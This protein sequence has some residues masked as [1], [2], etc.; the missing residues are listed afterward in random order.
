[1]LVN[2]P[3]I[4]PR[5]LVKICY[6]ASLPHSPA[7]FGDDH[8]VGEALEAQPKVPLVQSNDEVPFGGVALAFAGSDLGFDRREDVLSHFVR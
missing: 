4:T 1:L 2:D 3:T 6:S 8:L 5:V 7:I